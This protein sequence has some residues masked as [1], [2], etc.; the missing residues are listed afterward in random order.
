M[1]RLAREELYP[2][3]VSVRRWIDA[4][5]GRKDG[6]T[7]HTFTGKT[8]R[9]AE[10]LKLH[11][12][13]AVKRLANP[14][15]RLPAR[16]TFGEGVDYEAWRRRLEAPYRKLA[17]ADQL[18]REKE[19]QVTNLGRDRK[20]AMEEFDAVYAEALRYAEAALRMAGLPEK[21][22]RGLR[23]YYQRRRLSKSARK[24]RQARA[25]RKAAEAATTKVAAEIGKEEEK[26]SEGAAVTAAAGSS[27]KRAFG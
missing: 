16:K 25:G 2:E 19:R 5:L 10:P 22:I 1:Q 15:H 20:E 11:V 7:L 23:P 17:E 3:A 21:S 26:P 9:N 12:E 8:P 27:N 24:K 4:A 13:R 6:A 14:K 18:R